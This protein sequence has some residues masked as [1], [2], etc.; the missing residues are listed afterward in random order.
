MDREQIFLFPGETLVDTIHDKGIR[1][2]IVEREEAIWCGTLGH[3][4]N[5]TGEPDIPGLLAAYQ[6]LVPVEKR[7]LLAPAWTYTG[8]PPPCT[9]ASTMTAQRFRKSCLARNSAKCSSCTGPSMSRLRNMGMNQSL[10]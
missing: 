4:T 3:A 2:D 6:A 9:S 1:F 7:E 5:P 8:R 10:P